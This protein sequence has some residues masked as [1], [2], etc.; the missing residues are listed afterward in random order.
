MGSEMCIRDRSIIVSFGFFYGKESMAAALLFVIAGA[1]FILVAN[2]RFVYPILGVLFY[3]S[4][5]D[6]ALFQITAVLIFLTGLPVGSLFAAEHKG[7]RK[8][9]ILRKITILNSL[10]FAF[11]LP[12][13]FLNL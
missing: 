7:M 6:P 10:F 3:G 2:I 11:A 13:Y 9:R 1:A 5:I 12:L 4:N 8:M